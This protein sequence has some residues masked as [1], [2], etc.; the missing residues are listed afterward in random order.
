VPGAPPDSPFVTVVVPVRNGEDKIGDC[1]DSLLAVDY[2]RERHEILVVDNGSTDRTAE[3]IRSRPVTYLHEPRRGVS[4]ARNRGIAE[5]RGEILA[6]IDGDCLAQPDWLAEL[7]RPFADPDVGCVAGELGHEPGETTAERQA[8]RMFGAWQR[9]AVGSNPPYAITANAAYRRTVLD[10][11]GP[12]D[13]RMP[14][15]QDVEL[16]LR[17]NERSGLRLVYTGDAVVRHRHR[18]THGG[19]FRQQLGWSYGAGLVAAKYHAIDGRTSPPP[20]LRDVTQAARGVWLVAALRIRPDRDIPFRTEYLADA[21]FGLMRQAAWYL[22]ARAGMWRGA[23]LFRGEARARA[24]RGGPSY[25]EPPRQPAF[26]HRAEQ[27]DPD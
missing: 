13:P 26:E 18:S 16:G 5:G 24:D 20:R 9:Y 1:I 19:F 2:P 27:A 3:I 25:P 15:A 8:A 12:F 17:F 6:F 10:R 4:N 22:G 21:W 23:R 11:I 14:R 7:T